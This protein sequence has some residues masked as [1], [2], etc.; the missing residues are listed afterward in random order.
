MDYSAPMRVAYYRHSAG[1]LLGMALTTSSSAGELSA[2]VCRLC[3]YTELYTKDPQ[4][5]IVDGVNVREVIASPA[6]P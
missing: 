5:I 4:N 6:K 3:G 2:G 1:N